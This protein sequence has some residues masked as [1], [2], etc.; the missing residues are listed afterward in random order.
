MNSPRTIRALVGALAASAIAFTATTA[1]A[2][3]YFERSIPGQYVVSLQ[4]RTDQAALLRSLGIRP[5]ATYA[6]I[7]NGFAAPLSP[8]QYE[9]L[10]ANPSVIK[11]DIDTLIGRETQEIDPAT[12]NWGLDRIDQAQLPLSGTYSYVS[13]GKGV[14]AYVIDD[15]IAISHPD[16]GGRAVNAHDATG[17]NFTMCAKHTHGTQMASVLGGTRFGVAKEVSIHSVKVSRC[18]DTT[19]RSIKIAALEW[20]AVNHKKPALVSMSLSGS[21]HGDYTAAVNGLVSA[22]VFIASSAGNSDTG[23]PVGDACTKSPGN[24]PATFTVAASTNIDEPRP[25]SYAG[26]CVDL[27]APGSGIAATVGGG[28]GTTSGTSPATAM[29]AGAA[30]RI[31]S[32][33]PTASPAQVTSTLKTYSTKNVIKNNRPNTVSDLLFLP[34]IY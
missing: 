13:T 12:D 11:I 2:S 20:V 31:L 25:K 21:A 30:A 23:E 28:T 3:A 19:S 9:H 33:T 16:F 32:R 4:P 34:T 18:D 7:F 27:Y 14:N 15:G 24:V 17:E 8:S 5:T 10:K 26:P 1:T 6:R 22:G 29:V